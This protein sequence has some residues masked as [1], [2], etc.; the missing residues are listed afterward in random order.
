[1]EG[2]AALAYLPDHEPALGVEHFPL[3]AA[4]TSGYALAAGVDVLIHDAQYSAA[5]YPAHV[6]WGH[7]A[8]PQMLAFAA[9]AGVKRLV[10]FHH[11]PGHSDAALDQLHE[12]VRATMTLPFELT[13]GTE[14]SRF[15]VG[16]PE[17][18]GA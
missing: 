15:E 18:R 3:A 4:W 7:S 6:G 14:G 8:L 5:E 10:T 11:D 16:T 9:M 17:Q 1:M 12:E 2:E 13:A